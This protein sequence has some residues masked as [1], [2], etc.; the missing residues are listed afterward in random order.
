MGPAP[1]DQPAVLGLGGLAEGQPLPTGLAS[2]D[3]ELPKRG[4]AY[5]LTTPGGDVTVTARAASR[6]FLDGLARAAA[7]VAA[8]VLVLW[9]GRLA[10]AGLF[11]PVRGW[12]AAAVLIAVGFAALLAGFIVAAVVLLV[13]GIAIAVHWLV[14]R[15][16]RAATP[17]GSTAA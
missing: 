5:L 1:Q 12:P 9:I 7:V 6:E 14:L 10:A 8:A 15:R 3:F 2:L 16:Q 4:T 17:A 13:A 11:R